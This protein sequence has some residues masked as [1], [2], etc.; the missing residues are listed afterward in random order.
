MLEIKSRTFT[1]SC[2]YPPFFKFFFWD[3]KLPRLDSIFLL[4][5]PKGLG[6]QA[7][8]H[9]WLIKILKCTFSSPNKMPDIHHL[10]LILAHSVREL[11]SW[12]AGSKALTPWQ[13]KI[14]LSRSTPMTHLQPDPASCSVFSSGDSAQNPCT[15][16]HPQPFLKFWYSL[17]K[18]LNC[19]G[20]SHI[21]NPPAPNSQTVGNRGSWRT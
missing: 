6:L 19:L 2:I 20:W 8:N 14:C 10:K 7:R 12:S 9:A 15:E 4:Q 18:L 21:C 16:L 3:T 17:T 11:S 5:P 13:K 1:L